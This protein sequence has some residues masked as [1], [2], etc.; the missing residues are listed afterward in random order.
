MK[1]WPPTNVVVH[2]LKNICL[3]SVENGLMDKH[4]EDLDKMKLPFDYHYIPHSN[5]HHLTN[6]PVYCKTIFKALT[7]KPSKV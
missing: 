6:I 1:E 7:V 2:Y 4:S 3:Y 5:I